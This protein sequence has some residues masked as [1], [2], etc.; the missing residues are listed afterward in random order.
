MTSWRNPADE[1]RELLARYAERSE[2]ELEEDIATEWVLL[3][4]EFIAFGLVI[5]MVVVRQ[6][7][8]V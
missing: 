8:F 7:W 5:L 1:D 2:K 4:R 6:L 3:R